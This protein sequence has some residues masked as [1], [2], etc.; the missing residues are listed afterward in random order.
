M[1]EFQQRPEREGNS[2]YRRES[3]YSN[4]RRQRHK[5][6][7]RNDLS[8]LSMEELDEDDEKMFN[9]AG[10]YSEPSEYT[11]LEEETTH[12]SVFEGSDIDWDELDADDEKMFNLAGVGNE[13][14][15]YS[16]NQSQQNQ[17]ASNYL[18]AGWGEIGNRDNYNGIDTSNWKTPDGRD[19]PEEEKQ[20][21]ASVYQGSTIP[22]FV[23]ASY[24]AL[25]SRALWRVFGQILARRFGERA[26]FA[27]TINAGDPISPVAE[28]LTLGL[29]ALTIY[30]I[31]RAWDEIWGEVEAELG[32]PN[33]EIVVTEEPQNQVYTT[34]N[35]EQRRIEHTGGVPPHVQ[36]GTPPF[37][38]EAGREIESQQNTG[39]QTRQQPDARDFVMEWSPSM[40][41]A[42][43]DEYTKDSYYA[44]QTFYHGTDALSGQNISET[45]I[46]PAFFNEL[47]NYGTGFY[48]ARNQGSAREYA[49]LT[50][51]ETGQQQALLGVKLK[52][53]NP[54]IFSS[55][56]DFSVNAE[57]YVRERGLTNVEPP[58]AYGRYLQSQGYD[59]IEI[60]ALGYVVVFAPEQVVVIETE[61]IE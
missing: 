7:Y 54:V 2:N 23:I 3:S 61:V 60:E 46:D 43:A 1:N 30:Q 15:T 31:Y 4:N 20:Q 6:Y 58:D 5:P 44:E 28:L 14:D 12:N 55:G 8:N 22:G 41:P 45:G 33:S 36:T 26:A 51:E 34:P 56:V 49:E 50:A 53:N 48:T 47:S 29:A 52:A 32:N 19:L 59:A 17:V 42:E 38:T 25:G 21:I 18:D 37:D 10:V 24:G 13:R 35:E 27:A 16:T 11:L 40:T 57:N 39:G 9:L